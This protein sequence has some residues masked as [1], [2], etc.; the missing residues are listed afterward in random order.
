MSNVQE[1][2]A[3]VMYLY[4]DEEFSYM[5]YYLW[6]LSAVDMAEAC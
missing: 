4:K 6:T 5:S 3:A 1:F 2:N